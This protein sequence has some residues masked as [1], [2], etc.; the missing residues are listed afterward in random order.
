MDDRDDVGRQSTLISSEAD[1]TLPASGR[2]AAAPMVIGRY[3]VL[4]AIGAGGMGVVYAAQDPELDRTVA[5]KVLHREGTALHELFGEAQALAQLRHPNV[6]EVYDVFCEP[7][8]GRVVII[9]QWVQGRDA[10]AWQRDE[11]PS[12]ETVLALYR[13]AGR[14]LAAAHRAGLVHR[15]F[16]PANLLVTSDGHVRVAD[17]G[18]AHVEGEPTHAIAGTPAYMA[19]EQWRRAPATAHGDQYSFCAS[20]VEAL[21]PELQP[22]DLDDALRRRGVSA[23]VRRA[24]ARGLRDDPKQRFPTM[25]AL[26]AEL[27]PR[28]RRLLVPAAAAVAAIGSLAGFLAPERAPAIDACSADA[29]GMRA[30]WTARGPTLQE[31][32]DADVTHRVEAAVTGYADRWQ[33]AWK[34]TCAIDRAEAD[35]RQRCLQAQRWHVTALVDLLASARPDETPRVL[36]AVAALPAPASCEASAEAGLAGWMP[37]DADARASADAYRQRLAAATASFAAGRYGDGALAGDALLAELE[38]TPFEPLALLTRIALGRLHSLDGRPDHARELF[39]R[40]YF[41]AIA[42]GHDRE[43]AEAATALTFTVG[44]QLAEHERGIAWARH[45]EAALERLDLEG[46]SRAVLLNHRGTI[47][48]AIGDLDAATA[49]HEQALAIR[50]PLGNPSALAHTLNNL[51]NVALHARDLPR[52]RDYHARALELRREIYGASHPIVATSLNNLGSVIMLEQ[53]PSAAR[54]TFEQALRTWEAG[55]GPDHPDLLSAL[56]NLTVVAVNEDRLDDAHAFV[57]RARR[58]AQAK[59]P[60]DHPSMLLVREDEDGLREVECSR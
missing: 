30:D 41:D 54:S 33:T 38:Q 21:L 11:K 51:G 57:A 37:E 23:H 12:V 58:I 10:E 6:V 49:F 29:Q 60:P 25:E 46:E 24:L 53:D 16:K 17:F 44:Y 18:L 52:A 36:S 22:P 45:A 4:R 39:T 40:A 35:R 20:L 59:L 56:H 9:L 48:T 1:A 3:Q 7:D 43:A 32:F 19:P 27:S 42:A 15:D 26:L 34:A 31:H 8:R 5:I 28:R 14:G 50:E 55:L 2:E 13:A 47:A